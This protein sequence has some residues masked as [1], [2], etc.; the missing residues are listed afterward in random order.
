MHIVLNQVM[1]RSWRNDSY[2]I[3]KRSQISK[4]LAAKCSHRVRTFSGLVAGTPA[5]SQILDAG[6]VGRNA[7]LGAGFAAVGQTR[8]NTRERLAIRER[9]RP[10]GQAGQSCTLLQESSAVRVLGIHR[11][12]SSANSMNE[13]HIELPR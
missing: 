8:G 9:D 10:H 2:R 11:G 13:A 4:S 7:M 12:T 3:L 6:F 1:E 5:V